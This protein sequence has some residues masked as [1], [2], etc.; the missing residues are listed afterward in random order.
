MNFSGNITDSKNRKPLAY[1]NI[2][3]KKKNMGTVS[4]ENGTFSLNI[5]GENSNDTLTFSLVGYHELSVPVNKLVTGSSQNIQLNEKT[6][7]LNEVKVSAEKLVEKKYGIKKRSSLLHFTDGMFAKDDIFEIGQL[8]HFGNNSAQVISANLYIN[9]SRAD[10]ASFRINFY[11]YEDDRPSKRIIEKN[12]IQRH[13]IKE[14]W[15]SFDLTQYSIM[16]KGDFIVSIEFIPETKKDLSP[17]LYEVKLGGTS[18]SFYRKNSLGNWNSPPHH[19]CL[20]ITAMVNKNTPEE[21]DD[22]ETL[23]AWT[24]KSEIVKDTFSIFVRLP[25]DYTKNSDKKYPVLYHLDGNAYFDQ[26]SNSVAKSGKKKLSIE[27][28]VVGIGYRNELIMDSLRVRDYT[29]PVAIA[30][31]SFPTSG[32]AERFYG[33]I[34]NELIPKIEKMYRT[35]TTNR[36]IMGHSF[37]GYFTLYALQQDLNGNSVFNNYVS[38]SP[39][40]FYHDQYIVKKFESLNPGSRSN[41]KPRLFLTMGEMEI[42]NEPDDG[43]QYFKE[44]LQKSELIDIESKLY[45]NLEHMGTAI[46]SFE[47]GIEF[48][49]IH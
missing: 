39:S 42:T 47:D 24:L 44:L 16:L 12:I 32:G 14:G 46:P 29:F 36:T 45:K 25:A 8:I 26:I 20:Y 2:G 27:P 28:I 5:P 30:A 9:A 17:I 48:I 1:V 23:P 35:D 7:E 19:Y 40:L 4:L 31:D 10:S 37:G 43:F 33:F 22:K 49:F 15:L 18:R 3:I 11:R 6:I 38:A 34:R 13:S 41:T 21:T